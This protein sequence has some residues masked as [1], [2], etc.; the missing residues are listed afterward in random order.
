MGVGE[1]IAFI[2]V[3]R[4]GSGMAARLI[5]AGS[6]PALTPIASASAAIASEAA[7]IRLLASLTVWP[8]PGFSP[9]SYTLPSTSSSGRT[10]CM[11]AVGPE[12]MIASLPD[13][14]PFT[15]PDTGASMAL[16]P[17]GASSAAIACAAA[18]PEVDRS[19]NILSAG[20]S[21]ISRAVSRA[22]AG[23]GTLA[24]ATVLEDAASATELATFAPSAASGAVAESTGS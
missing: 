5:A 1:K 6:T 4:M 18:G 11:A 13:A 20:E 16:M 2:G 24:M 19:T 8:S 10:R 15:P 3:G 9:S 23:P 7:D 17:R 22:S 12:A 21:A 14:A